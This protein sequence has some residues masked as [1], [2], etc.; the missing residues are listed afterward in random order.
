MSKS[1]RRRAWANCLSSRAFRS[2]LCASQAP[3]RDPAF[4]C[5][6]AGVQLVIHASPP[7]CPRI[8]KPRPSPHRHNTAKGV[9]Q[10]AACEIIPLFP[11]DAQ[12]HL[13]CTGPFPSG[14]CLIFTAWRLRTWLLHLCIRRH[15][16]EPQRR[17]LPCLPSHV[18]HSANLHSLSR[19]V[20]GARLR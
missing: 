5:C 19:R 11:S 2:D 18:L 17:L 10:A 6:A 20:V 7:S 8:P 16:S 12:P 4:E 3:G 13:A 14:R 1:I 15:P 9:R